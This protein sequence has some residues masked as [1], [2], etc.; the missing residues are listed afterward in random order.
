MEISII[1]AVVLV[2]VLLV[3]KTMKKEVKNH[4]HGNGHDIDEL[5]G[6]KR[7]RLK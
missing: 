6:D 2:I 4:N 3:W 1:A 5:P 7:E